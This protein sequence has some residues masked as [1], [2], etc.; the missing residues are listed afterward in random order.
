MIGVYIFTVIFSLA[1]L[2]IS[3]FT[4]GYAIGKRIGYTIGK[5]SR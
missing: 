4:L 5:R 3:S 2:C 1:S